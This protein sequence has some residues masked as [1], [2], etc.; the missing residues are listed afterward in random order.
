MNRC[1]FSYRLL[2]KTLLFL[3]EILSKL[4]KLQTSFSRTSDN[5]SGEQINWKN[6]FSH[7]NCTNEK[8]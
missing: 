1:S 8:Q 6:M 5:G 7:K 4:S 3:K 2:K